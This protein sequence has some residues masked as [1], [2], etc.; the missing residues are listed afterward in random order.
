M[1]I[2]INQQELVL[3]LEAITLN[4]KL[5]EIKTKH[6]QLNNIL[7]RLDTS[8]MINDLKN[9][10]EWKIQLPRAIKFFLLRV[11]KKL[12]LCIQ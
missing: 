6:N 7:I 1:G 12:A 8:H 4:M 9:Q 11:L 3:L 5:M 10:G 2:I